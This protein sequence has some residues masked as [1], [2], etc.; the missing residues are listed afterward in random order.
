MNKNF[1]FFIIPFLLFLMG[2][3]E[4]ENTQTITN[5]TGVFVNNFYAS[6]TSLVPDQIF[7]LKMEL[8]NNGEYSAKNLIG[9]I[10]NIEYAQN[11][12][13]EGVDLSRSYYKTEKLTPN[14]PLTFYWSVRTPNP[15]IPTNVN[16]N[17]NARIYYEYKTTAYTDVHFVPETSTI[18]V[19]PQKNCSNSPVKVYLSTEEPVH[20]FNHEEDNPK[21]LTPFFVNVE[22]VNSGG[23]RIAYLN[24]ISDDQNKISFLENPQLSEIVKEIEI[25]YPST[26]ELANPSFWCA[27]DYEKEGYTNITQCSNIRL[28]DDG[29]DYIIT[30]IYNPEESSKYYALHKIVR[31]TKNEFAIEFQRT[32]V[33][34]EVVETME[35]NLK[36][37]Y[38][39]DANPLSLVI[40]G[41]Q[42]AY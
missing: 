4:T 27:E 11:S 6:R 5:I 15:N 22:M 18:T 33:N 7:N 10:Y 40:K 13:E 2:C 32:K 31:N 3:I 26:W 12:E 19:S 30:S 38:T 28:S 21:E 42:Q 35:I 36:Y 17:I 8:L 29:T 14:I 1:Y 41:S 25:T 23:G 34:E 16:L 24:E 37:G 20:T 39:V 9:V